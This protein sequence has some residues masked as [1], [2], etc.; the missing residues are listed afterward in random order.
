MTTETKVSAKDNPALANELAAKAMAE[1]QQ[2]VMVTAAKPVAVTTPP[3]LN[4]ELPGG[5]YD[6]FEGVTRTAQIRELTGADEE[7][8]ARITDAGKALLTILERATVKIGEKPADK[9]ALDTL[10]AGDREMILLAIRK[11]TF[12]NTVTVGPGFCP[13][14]DVE[15]T[16]TIDLDADVEVKKLNEEDRN[17]VFNGKI[18][19]I[20]V[21][22]PNGFV[23]KSIVTAA[24]KNSAE[25]D[26]LLLKG[27]ILSINDG[28]MVTLEHIK[29]LSLKDRR[30]VITEIT[31]RNP[32]PQL[33]EIKKP[34]TACGQ[35]VPL[36]L[37][38][39]DLFRE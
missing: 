24:N 34:C 10:L 1:A 27:C 32:G 17:F 30:D 4:V 7:A 14:C 12:G 9:D 33:S 35:E 19:K 13:S 16:F 36:P 15:Q 38:L 22:L 28:P 3:D 18:G 11:A 31:N 8:I 29:N 26:T 2:E 39:A 5:L 6:P 21:S 25:L 20:S 37:T 23:Q